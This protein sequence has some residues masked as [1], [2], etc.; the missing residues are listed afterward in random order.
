MVEDK[1]EFIERL[2][3][4]LEGTI[5]GIEEDSKKLPQALKTE[6]AFAYASGRKEAYNDVIEY[7]ENEIKN[8]S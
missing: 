8:T 6:F 4:I 7:L 5:K 1:K 2:K 3:K